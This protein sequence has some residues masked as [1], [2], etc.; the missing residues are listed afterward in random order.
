[1]RYIGFFGLVLFGVFGVYLVVVYAQVGNP[2]HSSRWVYDVYEAKIAYAQKLPSPKIV[3][4]AGSNV[5]FGVDSQMIEDAFGIPTVN[6]GVNAGV[7]LPIILYKT[8]Q[9]LREGDI[10]VMPLEYTMY[11]YDGVPNTQMIDYIFA[12]EP[13]IWRTLGVFERFAVV[14]NVTLA[15]VW[16]GYQ[17]IE[18]RA[19]V[20]LYSVYNIDQRGDQINTGREFIGEDFLRELGDAPVYRYGKAFSPNSLGMRYLRDFADYCE[21]NGIV[22]VFAPTALLKKPEYFSDAIEREFYM[23][24]PD[25]VRGFGMGFVGDPYAYMYEVDCF[26]NTDHHLHQECKKIRTAQ[27]IEDLRGLGFW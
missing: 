8:K 24:L 16:Q 3:V 19:A 5:L 9:I 11:G 13:R 23:G 7:F 14:W 12:R 15:R 27:L 25:I 17:K 1:M 26:F 4:S 10:L 21:E 2:T 22:L 6:F 18:D 20:G